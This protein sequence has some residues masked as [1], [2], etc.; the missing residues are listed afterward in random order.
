MA[1]ESCWGTMFEGAAVVDEGFDA[2]DSVDV[3]GR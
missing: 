3:E 1:A 2:S